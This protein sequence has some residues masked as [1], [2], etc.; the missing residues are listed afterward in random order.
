MVAA[1]EHREAAERDACSYGTGK[2][3]SEMRSRLSDLRL[4]VAGVDEGSAG[5]NLPRGG[6]VVP[7][8]WAARRRVRGVVQ[9]AR[10]YPQG[11][12]PSPRS[13]PAL[14]QHVARRADHR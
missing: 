10:G 3:R 13:T 11:R 8:T 7:T 5:E 14:T 6:A 2:A 4:D 1:Q 12:R 9:L